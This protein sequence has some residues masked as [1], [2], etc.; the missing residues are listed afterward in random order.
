MGP[1]RPDIS[2]FLGDVPIAIEMQVSSI[3]LD[4]IARRTKEYTRR[5]VYILWISPYEET[6]MRE[7]KLYTLRAWERYIHNLYGQTFYYWESGETLYPVH[8]GEYKPVVREKPYQP[9]IMHLPSR[10]ESVLITALEATSFAADFIGDTSRREIK[11]WCIPRIWVPEEGA[12]LPIQEAQRRYP[13]AY[14]DPRSLRKPLDEIP[15]SGDP[16]NET[17]LSAYE[18]GMLSNAPGGSCPIHKRLYR[19]IDEFGTPYCSDV[20]C[21]SRFRLMQ[22]GSERGYPELY[23]IVDTRDYLPDLSAEPSYHPTPLGNQ[24]VPVYPTR[25]PRQTVLIRAGEMHWR[26]Y[27]ADQHYVYIGQALTAVAMC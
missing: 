16:F 24:L 3:Q 15:F 21:W 6:S 5:G 26:T 14:P 20:E 10:Q 22:I 25:P 11:F 9:A 1:V 23:A 7:G 4:T 17:P 27:V 2:C 13:F 12:Y 18:K 19:F 8:F